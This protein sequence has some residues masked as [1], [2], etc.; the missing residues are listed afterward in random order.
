MDIKCFAHSAR[1]MYLRRL[2]EYPVSTSRTP[3]APTPSR[4]YA[5]AA[6]VPTEHEMQLAADSGRALGAIAQAKGDVRLTVTGDAGVAGQA[7]IPASALRLLVDAL[8][9]IASGNAVSLMP[10][11]AEITTQEAADLLN[12]SRPYLVGLL[13]TGKIPFRKVGVQR[14]VR[15]QDLMGYKAHLDAERQAALDALARQAQE[16]HLGYEE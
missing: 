6:L 14:R 13:D 8:A 15:L 9:A 1:F 7:Q 10:L 4:S 3:A 5:T 11:N 12:V 2:G 16:L